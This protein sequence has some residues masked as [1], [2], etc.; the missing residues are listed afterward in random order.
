M[1]TTAKRGKNTKDRL[2]T[3]VRCYLPSLVFTLVY[4]NGFTLALG[5]AEIFLTILVILFPVFAL[6]NLPW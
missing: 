4:P 5:A 6:R 3:A 2:S 1:A